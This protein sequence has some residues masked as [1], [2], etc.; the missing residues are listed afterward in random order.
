[1]Y[2]FYVPTLK[3]VIGKYKIWN[4]VVFWFTLV[5]AIHVLQCLHVIDDTMSVADTSIQQHLKCFDHHLFHK[6]SQLIVLQRQISI[7][8]KNHVLKSGYQ[9]FYLVLHIMFT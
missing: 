5:Y 7:R 3:Q 2:V 6:S 8:P 1:M 4:E 9:V